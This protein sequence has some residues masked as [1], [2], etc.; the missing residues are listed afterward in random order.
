[1]E[2]FF[3]VLFLLPTTLHM[4]ILKGT[5]ECEEERSLCEAIA[6]TSCRA[7]GPRTGTQHR[8]GK[9]QGML[10]KPAQARAVGRDLE[11]DGAVPQRCS[12]C[13]PGAVPPEWGP[14][15]ASESLKASETGKP[16]I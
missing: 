8:V 7:P 15:A 2:F 1:M 6:W 4:S 5:L 3:L 14:Q 10:S 9:A 11:R 12:D 16:A 13:F